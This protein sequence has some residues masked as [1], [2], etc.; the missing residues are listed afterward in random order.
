VIERLYKTAELCELWNVHEE[1][2]RKL[3]RRGELPS[4]RI[5]NERRYPESGCEEFLRARSQR[6]HEDGS[7]R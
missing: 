1:T 3:A 6:D 2:V 4:I 7:S 5:G